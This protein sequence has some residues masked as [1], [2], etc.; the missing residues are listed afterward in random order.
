MGG[1]GNQARDQEMGSLGCGLL[2]L[3]GDSDREM[4]AAVELHD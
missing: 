3:T 1:V 2:P 4:A